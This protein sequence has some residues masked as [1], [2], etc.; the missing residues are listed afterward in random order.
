MKHKMDTLKEYST[1]TFFF[2]RRRGAENS[3]LRNGFLINR[4]IRVNFV[5]KFIVSQSLDLSL[6]SLT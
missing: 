4:V 5:M 2:F 6:W 3:F 1:D